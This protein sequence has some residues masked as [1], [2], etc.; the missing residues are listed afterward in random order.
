MSIRRLGI[1]AALWGICA[2]GVAHAAYPDIMLVWT[3]PS[4]NGKFG[5]ASAYDLRYATVPIT[6][7]NF[8]LCPRLPNPPAALG[9]GCLQIY[10]VKG[11]DPM[12]IYFFALKSVDYRGNWSALSNVVIH[13]PDDNVLAVDRDPSS[14]LFSSPWPNPARSSTRIAYTLAAPGRVRVEAFDIGGRRVRTLRDLEE[15][16]GPATIDWDLR[17]DDGLSLA[18][19]LYLI[20]AQLNDRVLTRRVVVSR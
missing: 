8:H 14:L 3:A 6:E 18:P 19:G 5:S 9:A 12:G 13:T 20:R 4:D 16:A 11:F 2:A 1:V 15:P 17:G 10:A 7:A